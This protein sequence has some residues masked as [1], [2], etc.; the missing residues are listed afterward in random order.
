MSDGLESIPTLTV[1]PEYKADSPRRL[2]ELRALGPVHRVQLANGLRAW[3]VVTHREARQALTHPAIRKDPSPAEKA[4]AAAGFTANRPG[5]GLGGNMLE[6]DPPSHTRL[7]RLVSGAFSPGRTA[8]LAPR[9]QQIADDLLD[10]M[11]MREEVD[12]VEAF[13][14]PLPITVISELLGV[15]DQD[16]K[17]FREWTAAAL[18]PPSAE[19]RAGAISLNR[20]MRS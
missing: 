17:N 14:A 18:S 16:R 19:Q 5:V 10:A 20:F 1:T 12:L 11:A 6:S 2:A 15:P 9:I 13:N 8:Q 7:R 3:A 4:L